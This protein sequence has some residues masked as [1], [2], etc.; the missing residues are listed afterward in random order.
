MLDL[1]VVATSG[2][3]DG[4]TNDLRAAE[5]SPKT[6]AEESIGD[7]LADETALVG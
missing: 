3:A 7:A 5:A 2:A 1:D 4:S 6:V